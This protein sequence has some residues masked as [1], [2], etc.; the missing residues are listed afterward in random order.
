MAVGAWVWHTNAL[1][2]SLSYLTGGGPATWKCALF[3]SA[4]NIVTEETYASLTNEVASGSGY[5]TGGVSVTFTKSGT[6]TVPVTLAVNP[7]WTPSGADMVW[8]WAVIYEVGGNVLGYCLGDDSPA[9][10]TFTDGADSTI[11]LITNGFT[12]FS[13][14]P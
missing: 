12:S 11:D 8:R 2:L 10:T 4:S 1:S 9:D 13:Q 14:A 7:N 3:T 6:T 5:T